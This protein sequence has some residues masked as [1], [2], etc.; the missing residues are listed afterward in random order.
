MPSYE[1][2]DERLVELSDVLI[3]GAVS[4]VLV[5]LDRPATSCRTGNPFAAARTCRPAALV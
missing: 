3:S 4:A 1:S 2:R 5:Y